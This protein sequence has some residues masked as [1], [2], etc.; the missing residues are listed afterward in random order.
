M[1]FLLKCPACGG[2][3]LHHHEVIVCSRTSGED[4][5]GVKVEVSGASVTTT[6]NVPDAAF[7]GRRDD[8][9]VRFTCEQCPTESW[10]YLI[11]HK[12]DT[13]LKWLGHGQGSISDKAI[14]PVTSGE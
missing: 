10:R 12:G 3:N 1:D 5:P 4:G 2:T 11:Q 8:L 6:V 9:R 7:A 14:A 13:L